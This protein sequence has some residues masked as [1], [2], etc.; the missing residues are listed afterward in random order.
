MRGAGCI[1]RL[2]G[3]SAFAAIVTLAIACCTTGI[4][5]RE[6][7]AAAKDIGG[8]VTVTEANDGAEISLAPGQ[9]L[10]VSLESNPTTGYSWAVSEIDSQVLHEAARSMEHPAKTKS[11]TLSAS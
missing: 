2:L 10:I 5:I 8:V 3:R 6:D 7:T 11:G 1:L 4:P 9:T